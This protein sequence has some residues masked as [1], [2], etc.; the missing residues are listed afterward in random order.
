MRELRRKDRKATPEQAWEIINNGEYGLLGT[1]DSTGQPYVVPLSYVCEGERIYFHSALTGHKI[2]NINE[3]NKVS[4]CVVGSTKPV[5][6]GSFTTYYE[7]AIAFGTACLVED[8]QE[9]EKALYRLCERYLPG[10]ME[11]APEEI[12]RFNKITTVYRIDVTEISGKANRP[13][14]E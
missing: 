14:P 3:N 4:F 7:S 13:K 9:K 6:N 8:A 1:S 5:Y 2:E 10:D 11:K 12:A